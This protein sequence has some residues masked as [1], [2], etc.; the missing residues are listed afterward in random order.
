MWIT[1]ASK[2]RLLASSDTPAFDINVDTRDGVVTLFGMVDS[3]E[4]KQ[5]AEAEVRKV[6]GVKNVVNDLQVVADSRKER[7]EQTDEMLTE[8]IE[9]RLKQRD[10]GSDVTVEVT[11]RVARLSGE[12]A[13]SSEHLTAL[14]LARSTAGVK[15]VI[16]DLKVAP[17]AV[18]SR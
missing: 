3:A 4:A 1:G 8:T 9:S 2:V 14:T 7:V 12:V 18:S 6:D 17:P 15:Q 5:K 16:D 13:S 10:P 11:N